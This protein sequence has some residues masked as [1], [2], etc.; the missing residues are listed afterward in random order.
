MERPTGSRERTLEEVKAE[1]LRRAG[2]VNPVETIRPADAEAVMTALRSLDRDHW[3]E[4]WC[5]IGLGYE[6]RADERAKAGAA[7][8]EVRELY[9]QGFD[10]CRVGRYPAPTSPGPACRLPALAAHLSQG[11]AAVRAG[12]QD[13]RTAVRGARLWS[14]ISSFLRELRSRRSSC[15]GAVSTAGRR[16]GSMSAD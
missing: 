9:M 2:R 7:R 8:D 15:I 11:R 13:R 16:T 6:A 12:T 3:A 14:G 1:V 10:A 4:E 5:K